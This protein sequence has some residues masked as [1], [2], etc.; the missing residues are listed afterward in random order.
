M[1]QNTI[2]HDR[3][4]TLGS[5]RIQ[6]GPYN[7]RLYLMELAE[8]DYPGIVE[9]IDK[10]CTE[11]SYAK[12]FVIVPEHCGSAFTDNGYRE[13]ARI[14]GFFDGTEDGLF[15]GKFFDE[16]RDAPPKKKVEQFRR[17]M[18]FYRPIL[19]GRLGRNLQFSRM[20]E[21]DIPEMARLYGEIFPDYPFP[22]DDPDFLMENMGTKTLYYG[23]RDGKKLI[24]L[25]SAE[26]NHSAGAAEMTDFAVLP[27]YRGQRLGVKLLRVLEQAAIQKGLPTAYTIARLDSMGMN[28][29]FKRSGYKYAGTLVKNTR[30]STGIESMNVW[31]KRL[32]SKT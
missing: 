12:S 13:E 16:E 3:I 19:P 21:A 32:I 8:E 1:A 6:H 5:S 11:K 7:N 31:Y 27:K 15:M 2:K 14:P 4:E 30:I 18:S 25:A 26:I 22:I 29:V 20:K 28:T 10:I 9:K 17:V 23:I 24:A